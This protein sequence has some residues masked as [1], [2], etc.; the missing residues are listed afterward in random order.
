M[1]CKPA[2]LSSFS[3]QSFRSAPAKYFAMTYLWKKF[4]NLSPNFSLRESDTKFLRQQIKKFVKKN[5]SL[6]KYFAGAKGWSENR[7]LVRYYCR[8]SSCRS[9]VDLNY[10][11]TTS[12]LSSS[13]FR[14]IY[15]T[16]FLPG[17]SNHITEYQSCYYTANEINHNSWCWVRPSSP[18]C[19]IFRKIFLACYF[20]FIRHGEI[21]SMT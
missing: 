17:I 20:S 18:C 13:R 1:T 7:A 3:T 16:M 12:R 2:I 14:F 19:V 4:F 21:S 6:A 15:S 8:A 5:A 9:S 10:S 11:V